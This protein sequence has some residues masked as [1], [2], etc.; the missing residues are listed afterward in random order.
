MRG[1]DLYNDAKPPVS[2]RVTVQSFPCHC[3]LR[4][5]IVGEEGCQICVKLTSNLQR[6]FVEMKFL[7]IGPH[8]LANNGPDY[9]KVPNSDD[10]NQLFDSPDFSSHTNRALIVERVLAWALLASLCALVLSVGIYMSPKTA[11]AL[12]IACTERLSAFSTCL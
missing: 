3:L 6:T 10:G 11:E 12:D 7:G 5:F 1:H 9:E 8:S 2:K 4:P